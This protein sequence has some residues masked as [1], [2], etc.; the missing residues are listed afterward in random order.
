MRQKLILASVLCLLLP[1]LVT[2][3]VGNTLTSGMVRTQ[4]MEAERKSLEQTDLYI[5][6]FFNT[7]I[8]ISNYILFDSSIT[9]TLKEVWQDRRQGLPDSA[10][11]VLAYDEINKNLENLAAMTDKLYITLL[12]SEG[13][14]FASYQYHGFD[15]SSM[16]DEPWMEAVRELPTYELYWVGTTANRMVADSSDDPHLV[17]MA[18][19]LRLPSGTPY[20]YML[21]SLGGSRLSEIFGTADTGQEML[22]LDREGT[23]LIGREPEQAGAVFGYPE[24]LL[25]DEPEVVWR[26]QEELLV[27]SRPMPYNGY[28]LVSLTPYRAALD[29]FN[30]V[31][32]LSLAIQIAAV[33]LFLLLFIYMVRQFTKPVVMLGRV[34]TRVRDGD[35]GV[36]SNLVGTDEVGQL[37][38]SFDRMLDSVE[39]MIDQITLEQAQKRRAEL[40]MLQAQINPHFL[41]NILNSIRLRVLMRG[42]EENAELI[43][44]LSRLL[45]MTIQRSDDYAP[46]HEELQ[47]VRQYVDLLNFRQSDEVRLRV[48]A[49]SDSLPAL[50]PRFLLQPIIENAYIHGLGEE[51]GTIAISAWLDQGYV[52]IEIEDDG[53]GMP[54][55]T[56][57]RLRAELIGYA[58]RR[59]AETAFTSFGLYNIYERLQLLYGERFQIDIDSVPG[60]GT[61]VSLVIPEKQAAKGGGAHEEGHAGR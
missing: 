58:D 41:F 11:T 21:V 51:G 13:Q 39:W 32:T 10:E 27:S 59:E 12:T 9:S 1:S 54:E 6:N 28:Q 55:A 15:P 37:A 4:V 16:L 48:D 53:A 34:A 25:R 19:T 29:R 52:T 33:G 50:V 38:S 61:K 31:Y 46:L 56:L 24:A 47:I 26:D 45:R 20:A 49:A 35:L 57:Q 14:Y 8:L 40:A 7:M 42:D 44:A 22:L 2:L 30:S 5:S 60:S 3:I 18:R 17:T 43:G 36:R 23:V